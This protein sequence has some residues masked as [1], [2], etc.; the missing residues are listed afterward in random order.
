[1]LSLLFYFVLYFVFT[2]NIHKTLAMSS[3]PPLLCMHL[4][5]FFIRE[6]IYMNKPP[7]LSIMKRYQYFFFKHFGILR[8]RVS[9]KTKGLCMFYK[10]C[11]LLLLGHFS[12]LKLVNEANNHFLRSYMPFFKDVLG[13]KDG[14]KS[15]SQGQKQK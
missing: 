5:G 8:L 3:P 14:S 7:S 10:S 6:T 9:T 13:I 1:M 4:Q 11:I 15:K 12:Q 2:E